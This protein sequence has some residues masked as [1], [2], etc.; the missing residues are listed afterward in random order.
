MLVLSALARS[1][2][3][4][5]QPSMRHARAFARGTFAVAA[6]AVAAFAAFA[7]AALC[8]SLQCAPPVV[9][10][11]RPSQCC[12]AVLRRQRLAACPLDAAVPASCTRHAE[13]P[14][15]RTRAR[16]PSAFWWA[17]RS[18]M[19]G[20][21]KSRVY[22]STLSGSSL[23]QNATYIEDLATLR[24]SSRWGLLR[25]PPVVIICS[26]ARSGS[27]HHCTLL[28]LCSCA[29][30]FAAFTC[31]DDQRTTLVEISEQAEG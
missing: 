2:R 22:F 14:A 4:H 15:P 12:A 18:G 27:S 26:P 7:V 23:M 24:V 30:W 10:A 16:W 3:S 8:L 5:L 9:T 1:A 6:F 29:L 25:R 31:G 11:C 19:A 21:P 17:T 20:K 28:V 13:P